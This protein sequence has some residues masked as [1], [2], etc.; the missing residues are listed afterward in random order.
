[1]NGTAAVGDFDGDGKLDVAAFTRAGMLWVW[2]TTGVTVPGKTWPKFQH[3]LY[4]SGN[5]S[6][7]GVRPSSPRK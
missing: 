7:P 6:Q 2:K 5:Y 1:V 4:N 3:D